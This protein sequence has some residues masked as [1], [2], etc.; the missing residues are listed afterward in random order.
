MEPLSTAMQLVKKG[1]Y[2]PVIVIISASTWIGLLLQRIFRQ[3][4]FSS[5]RICLRKL[6]SDPLPDCRNMRSCT[7]LRNVWCFR[8]KNVKRGAI[9]R[10][11]LIVFLVRAQLMQTFIVTCYSP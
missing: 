5:R 9:W 1:N 10:A 6:W 4:S 11:T 7:V 2:E 8:K 3:L